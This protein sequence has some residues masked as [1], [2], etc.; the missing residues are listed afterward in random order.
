MVPISELIK[1]RHIL[2]NMDKL[3]GE[4]DAL[5][6]CSTKQNR[7]H[8]SRTIKL[9]EALDGKVN[10][11]DLK[12]ISPTHA[13]EIVRAA[14]EASWPQWVQRCEDEKLVADFS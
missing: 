13:S 4:Y 14:P 8:W 10:F 12:T 3:K 9:M 1:I 2:A 7:T 5:I 6:N 11:T